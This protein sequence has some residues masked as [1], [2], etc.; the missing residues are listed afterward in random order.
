MTTKRL[1]AL[2]PGKIGS[3]HLKNR[4]LRMGANPWPGNVEPPDYRIPQR[5]IEY[6]GQLAQG[7][8][9]LVTIAGG[10]V[11]LVSPLEYQNFRIDT[12]DCIPNI[13]A[14]A[15]AIHAGG[16]PALFQIMSPYPAFDPNRGGALSLA[17]ST[18]TQEDM[19]GLVPFLAPPRG[20]TKEEIQQLVQRYVQTCARLK[21]A[22]FDGIELNSGHCHFH[23]TFLSPAWN[24]RTDE[25]GGNAENRT[26]MLREIIQAVKAELGQ[27]FVI[28][29][30]ITGSEYNLQNGITVADAIA[31]AQWLESA[32]SDAI[33]VRNEVYHDAREG[34]TVRTAH[35]VPD[36]ELY[37]AL[38]NADLRE[39]GIDTSFGKGVAAWS[40]AAAKIKEA[41]NVPVICSG[42]MDAHVASKLISAGKL[43]F[44]NHCRRSIA[45]H[46]YA[47]KFMEDREADVRPC[48]GCF[49]CYETSERALI[50]WC[51]VN[52]S[53]LGGSEYATVK[54]APKRKKVL[55]I[56]SGAA[57]LEAAR[58]AALRGHD[59]TIVEKE[60]A[61]G[62]SLP[63]AAFIKDFQEDF[64]G[65]SQWQV[66]QVEK[67]G[68]ETR[69][70]C[71]ATPEFVRQ[72]GADVVVVAVGGA[73]NVPSL[74]GI[75]N[76]IVMTGAALHEQLK[77][78]TKFFN[79][80]TLG[81]LSKMFL[82]LGKRIV[83]MGG[84]LHGVQTARFLVA[85]GRKVVIVETSD[86]IGSGLYDCGPKPQMLKWLLDQGTEFITG[87][88]FRE[89]TNEGLIITNCTG[90]ERLVAADNIVT[91]LPMLDNLA[92]YES[93][94]PLAEEVYAIGDC[95]RLVIDTDLPPLIVQPV[96]T[97]SVWP[98]YTST[99]IR[100][101]YR[102]MR[103][104]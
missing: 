89:I 56:G 76:K 75:N 84:A 36:I 34:I 54:P 3:L 58:V 70:N 33:H 31:H 52:P 10:L 40:L 93:V 72:F 79:P 42:R 11:E 101:A 64:L 30:L 6:Y 23:N 12:D 60:A 28:I 19:N 55:V 41:V 44:I 47:R 32:G 24:R 69:L 21:A 13:K 20:I 51:M 80:A 46:D 88:V 103:E 62:G 63:L 95:N 102:I 81:K 73:E 68:V 66:R 61:L 91:A 65:F 4:L 83:V 7:G 90:G 18:L 82:P 50:S 87:A 71:E 59:V 99:A 77:A 17:A 5:L 27:D 9:G 25:Y 57:G 29:N 48:T 85:R 22:G 35:E 49:T 16:C 78:A 39:Y 38:I 98:S 104:V 45:D 86:E 2:E 26:R 37:P 97:K 74:P 92:L 43:D 1:K 100:E 67:L 53:N 94:K 8:A 14:V 96:N 15:D